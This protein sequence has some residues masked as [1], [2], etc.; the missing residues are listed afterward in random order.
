MKNIILFLTILLFSLLNVQEAEA[1]FMKKLLDPNA[2]TQPQ[3]TNEQANTPSNNSGKGKSAIIGA[4]EVPSEFKADDFNISGVYYRR[5]RSSGLVY[6][7]LFE[8]SVCNEKSD[9]K[10]AENLTACFKLKIVEPSQTYSGNVT[11]QE[12]NGNK[13]DY[14]YPTYLE[15]TKQ[16]YFPGGQG[17]PNIFSLAEGVLYEAPGNMNT[18]FSGQVD[19]DKMDWDYLYEKRVIYVKNLDDLD[20]WENPDKE[21]FKAKIKEHVSGINAIYKEIEDKKKSAN[22]LPTI[23][24]LNTKV[25]QNQAFKT[26]FEKYEPINKGW[27]HMYAYVHGDKWENKKAKDV[28]GQ[29]YDTHRE[30]HV[31]IVRKSPTGECRADLMYYVEMYENGT[32][33]AQTGKVTGPVS[34]IGMPGGPVPCEKAGSFKSKLIN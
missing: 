23:G 20:K 11:L 27:T 33:N 13:W 18:A 28:F 15:R 1:Q 7:N 12:S 29:W 2:Q 3:Q 24:K 10:G 26:Y 32:Y 8:L 16:L 17:T 6:K 30:L 25:L 9:A 19:W 21:E 34:Y 31:V 5:S 4:N 22:E 14:A